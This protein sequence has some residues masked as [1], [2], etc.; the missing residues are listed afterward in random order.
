MFRFWLP[1]AALLVT[2]LG[3]AQIGAWPGSQHVLDNGEAERWRAVGSLRMAGMSSCTAVLISQTQA[4]TA[5]HC[6]VDRATGVRVRLGY[7][8]LV[9]GQRSNGYAAVRKVRSVAFLPGFVSTE[10]ISDYSDLSSDL[11]L[12]QLDRPVSADEAVPI[13]VADW[14]HPIGEFV[15]IVGYERDGPRSPTIRES[16]RAVESMDTVTVVTCSVITGISGSPVLLSDRPQDP[17]RLVA[18]ASSRGDGVA[19]VVSIAPHLAAL[20]DLISHHVSLTASAS[21]SVT[22]PAA[23]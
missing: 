11:A 19:Y 21:R 6:V 9:L 3:A 13:E 4:L 5:A 20:R 17:P 16:C 22:E 1:S 8:T 7:F 12:L 18:S 14:P 2:L 23:R 10:P 15:D